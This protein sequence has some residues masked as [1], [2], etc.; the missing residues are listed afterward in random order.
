[1]NGCICTLATIKKIATEL[2]VGVAKLRDVIIP[3]ALGIS[4]ID[5]IVNAD[6]ALVI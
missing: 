4:V 6:L 3:V 2:T 1:M 5:K